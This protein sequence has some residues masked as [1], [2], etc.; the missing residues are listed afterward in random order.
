MTPYAPKHLCPAARAE[1]RRLIGYLVDA[2]LY[3]EVDQAALEMYCQ[4]YGRWRE[5]EA[6]LDAV[7]EGPIQHGER[8]DT[9]SAWQRVANARY[10]QARRMLAEFGLTPAQRSRVVA[11]MP[12][13]MDELQR[14]DAVEVA[15]D[16]A[17]NYLSYRPRSRAEIEAYLK[18]RRVPPISIQTVMDRLVGAGLL[19]DEAF[20]QYWVE[21]R[22]H[23]R[24]RGIRSLRFELRQK[25]VPDAVIDKAITNIDETESAYRAGRERAR[26]LRRLDYQQF[27]RR[28][29]GFLQRRGFGYD[30]VKVIV[31][32]LWRELQTSEEEPF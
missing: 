26:R 14:R 11:A 32:R 3:L 24:P 29:G 8:G 1:W 2:G 6:A 31:D 25:G 21:N 16:R 22:E 5:A 30:V 7:E 9:V 20:A 4:A 15:Y 23:F 17:L 13:E 18:R 28:L 12:E 19:D 27:R 10:D